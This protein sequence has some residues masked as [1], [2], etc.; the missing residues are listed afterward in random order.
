MKAALFIGKVR[1]KSEAFIS[2]WSCG[3]K[4]TDKIGRSAPTGAVKRCFCDKSNAL[5]GRVGLV[6]PIKGIFF[7]IKL[8]IK[9]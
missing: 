4:S 6:A 2:I 7:A 9:V 1:I 5:R 8:K 3:N